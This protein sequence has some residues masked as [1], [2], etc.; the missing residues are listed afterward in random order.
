[1][2]TGSVRIVAVA[3][4]GIVVMGVLL[5]LSGAHGRNQETEQRQ[6]LATSLAAYQFDVGQD[7]NTAAELP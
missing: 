5:A 2:K 7:G 4:G 1:M 3:T 6:A